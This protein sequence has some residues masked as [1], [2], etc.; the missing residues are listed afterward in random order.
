MQKSNPE[1][2]GLSMVLEAEVARALERSGLLGAG[3]LAAVSG[4]VDSVCLLHL[5]ARVARASGG[6]VEV[7][8]VDHGLRPGSAEDAS[9]CRD[10][11]GALA[12]PF[13][14]CRL[15]REAFGGR[16]GRQAR[17]RILRR[18]FLED[19]RARRGLAAVALGHHRDDQVETVLFRLL[20]GVGPRGVAGM[21]AWAPPYVRPLLAV[22][23][24][25]L[26]ALAREEGWAFREDPT[27]RTEAYARNRLRRK[28][29]PLLRSVHPGCDA[30]LLRYARL[31]AEDDAYL[32]R[33]ARELL[34]AR[35]VPEPEGL[36]LPLD[37]LREAGA[38]VRRR[39]YLA[40]WEAVGGEPAGL[41]SRHLEAVDALLGPGR[42]HRFAP[43]PGPGRFAVSYGDLWVLR[44]G[45]ADPPP[46]EAFLEGPGT[47]RPAPDGPA[48][49]WGE[50]PPPGTPHVPVAPGR[51]GAGVRARTWRPGDRLATGGGRVA[52]VKDLL[53]EARVPAWR[54]RRALLLA[55][56][57]GPLGLLAAGRAW[58]GAPGGRGCLWLTG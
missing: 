30:G 28:A 26:E 51:A 15:E 21:A 56:E 2:P 54:R 32:S 38:P 52:K 12:A 41:E 14:F 39:L 19:T 43:V 33:L 23:R 8:H 24:A 4:G 50:R 55:D 47:V 16:G 45:A 10:L 35:A 53:M 46:V 49:V 42:A 37:A 13:H 58:G 57:L 6:R 25:D 27:N 1:P 9:F 11:A 20:R 34:A 48:V 22:S 17:A 44:P 29:L 31:A 18:R 36:R 40:A 7:A 5:L 3:V